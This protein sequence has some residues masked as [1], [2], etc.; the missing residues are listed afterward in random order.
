MPP[1]EEPVVET[2]IRDKFPENKIADRLFGTEPDPA[3][4]PKPDPTPEPK[5]EPKPDPAPDPAPEPVVEDE[6]DTPLK[7]DDKPEDIDFETEPANESEARKQAKIRGREAKRLS[8]ERAALQL[9]LDK[10]KEEREKISKRLEEIESSA[11]D[12]ME[13]PDFKAQRAEILRD[14]EQTAEL[15]P[16]VQPEAVVRNFGAIMNEYLKLEGL[17]GSERS[18]MLVKLK[19]RVV[20]LLGVSELPYEELTAEEQHQYVPLVS[21]IL[22]M[23]HRN[24][25]PTKK[26]G[27]LKAAL[28]D[29]TKNGF[30]TKGTKTYE[31]AV[32]ELRPALDT[33]GEL[34]DELI[35][36]DPHSPASVVA[37]LIRESPEGKARVEKA[38]ADVLEVLVGPPALSLDDIR[39]L[40]A[41]GTNVKQFVAEREAAFRAKQKR[42][43]PLL[44]QSLVTRAVFKQSQAE[45]AK[46]KAAHEADESELDAL[47]GL[48][49]LPAPKKPDAAKEKKMSAVD[50]LFDGEE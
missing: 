45:L 33:V 39:R 15:L 34:T 28:E 43:A 37:K 1:I 10:E 14:V 30:I 26:L 11:I 5:P 42:L 2:P 49:K 19:G 29:R 20:D 13:H 16:M 50:K 3:P 7:K 27:E 18:E 24:V 46:L 8:A 12:P 44:V 40:E 25:G 36:A 38:K 23:I 32:S 6:W 22:R 48:A 41:N 17:T 35:A 4:E 21:D 47:T 31:T 9:Q